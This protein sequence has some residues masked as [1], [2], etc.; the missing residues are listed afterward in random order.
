ME[1]LQPQTPPEQPVTPEQ[2]AAPNFYHRHKRAL[3][4]TLI[5][6]TV[7]VAGLLVYVL[8]FRS[9][10][11]GPQYAGDVQ[12]EIKAPEEGVS[13]SEIGYEI[14]FI[15]SSNA[16]LGSLVMEIFYP[17]GFT[18][19][20][21]T[22][23]PAAPSG[24]GASPRRFNFPDLA[25]G[26]KH[27]LVIVGKLEGSVQEVKVLSV[28]LHYVPENFRSSFVAEEN[29]HTVMLAPDVS[30]TVSAPTDIIVGQNMS[31]EIKVENIS[32]ESFTNLEVRATYPENF[33]FKDSTP[34]QS[35][36]AGQDKFMIASLGPGAARTFTVSGRLTN[37][38][39]RESLVAVELFMRDEAGELLSAGRSFA[40]TKVSPPPLVLRQ[41]LVSEEAITA[42]VELE[43]QVDYENA[44]DVALGNVAISLVFET[45]VFELSQ[46]NPSDGGQLKN[47]SLVWTAAAAPD[48]RV[49]APGEKGTFEFSVPIL[50]SATALPKNPV[51]KT[52][53]EFVSDEIAEA[54]SAPAVELKV[55]TEMTLAAVSRALSGPHP[56]SPGQTTNFEVTVTVSNTVNDVAGAEF[57]ATLARA[58]ADFLATMISPAAEQGNVTF[59]KSSGFLRW[60]LGSLPA[61]TGV[62][63]AA[64]QM[65]FRLAVTPEN[66][67][68]ENS[69]LLE[70]LQIMGTDQHLGKKIFSN[71]L[72]RVE[73]EGN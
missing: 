68:I 42:G 73:V 53:L 11:P 35:P 29:A 34:P 48:L 5:T 8:F 65:S 18:F 17:Q 1:N 9:T 16:T 56:P 37:A 41:Q 7:A 14:S 71:E 44:G 66:S 31:Y 3:W 38:A 24:S 10:T 55:Q 63:N 52:R 58:D 32:S 54:L 49:V 19:V 21:S 59:S 64:R 28:K 23:D 6:A 61:F 69:V 13:G 2:P 67:V 47:R 20:D 46:I 25:V 39:E 62:K 57:S 43:Y 40:F 60:S 50:A 4:A 70:N 12:L 26:Q 15:N 22:P 27:K 45:P 30:L 36:G 33:Q 51:A 72:E